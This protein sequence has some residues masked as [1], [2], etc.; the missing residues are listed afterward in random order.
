MLVNDLNNVRRFYELMLLHDKI[1]TKSFFFFWE[2]HGPLWKKKKNIVIIS[3]Q[4]LFTRM[5]S[6]YSNED[7]T[8]FFASF[9]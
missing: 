3:S 4:I 5:T 2:K 6:V 7:V 1:S 8:E 9:T